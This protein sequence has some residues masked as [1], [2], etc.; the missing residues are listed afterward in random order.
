MERYIDVNGARLWTVSDGAGPAIVLMHAAIVDHRAWDAMVPML[1]SAGYQVVRYDARGFGRSDTADVEFS[2]RA[3]VLAVLDAL[4]I[5]AAALVGNSRGGQV[6]I[7][8]AIEFPQRVVAV[9]AVGAGVGGFEGSLTPDEQTLLDEMDRLESADPTDIAAIAEINVRIW[10]DGPGQPAGRAPGPVREAVRAMDM[11]NDLPHRVAGRPIRL[12]PLANERLME[13]RCPVLAVAGGLDLSD[14]PQ[15]GERLEA[16]APNARAVVLPGIAHM[17]GMEDPR[18][19]SDLV[20]D[21]LRP[22]GTWA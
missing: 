6:A 11:A 8:T 18:R 15:V 22:L 20:I 4:D 13:L 21:F 19:L 16:A 10:V 2:N 14:V 17:V 7:D 3:D 12:V 5:G 1:V 9:V